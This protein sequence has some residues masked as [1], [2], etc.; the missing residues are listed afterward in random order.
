MGLEESGELVEEDAAQ[1]GGV[2]ELDRLQL[3]EER[4][5]RHTAYDGDLLDPPGPDVLPATG[6]P[7]LEDPVEHP[8]HPPAL[9]ERVTDVP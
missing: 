5:V 8:Q 6:R 1:R 2:L 4:P 3:G 9:H 7:L